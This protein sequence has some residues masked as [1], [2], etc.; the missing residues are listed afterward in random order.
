M[1]SPRLMRPRANSATAGVHLIEWAHG[2]PRPPG[3]LPAGSGPAQ[4][5]PAP[6][7]ADRPLAAGELGGALLASGADGAG[8]GRVRP[9]RYRSG[10]GDGDGRAARP[11]RDLRRGPGRL[12]ARS[13]PGPAAAG[14]TSGRRPAVPPAAA[15][16]GVRAPGAVGRV[17]GA[18]DGG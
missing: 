11:G 2:T 12:R 1:Q 8:A 17:R 18:D 9:A 13:R 4:A 16:P 14:L 15:R 7:H 5:R 3:R 6:E 10:P